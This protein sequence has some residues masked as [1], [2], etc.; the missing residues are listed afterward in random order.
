MNVGDRVIYPKFLNGTE[1]PIGVYTEEAAWKRSD[2]FTEQKRGILT[3][4]HGDTAYAK[5]DHGGGVLA[6]QTDFIATDLDGRPRPG[7]PHETW[8]VYADMLEDAGDSDCERWRDAYAISGEGMVLQAKFDLLL[9]YGYWPRAVTGKRL[10]LR[11]GLYETTVDHMYGICLFWWGFGPGGSE[12]QYER[13]LEVLRS[14]AASTDLIHPFEASFEPTNG[15]RHTDASGNRGSNP[16]IM[17]AMRHLAEMLVWCFR[18]MAY[19][20]ALA[21]EVVEPVGLQLVETVFFMTEQSVMTEQLIEQPLR[22]FRIYADNGVHLMKHP[23]II[24]AGET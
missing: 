18:P 3:S 9:K 5:F 19:D 23:G 10:T 1:K 7:D 24:K 21:G 17:P 22:N 13:R 2:H 6:N 8:L 11:R 20:R 16:Y 15:V 4:V 12:R 14:A